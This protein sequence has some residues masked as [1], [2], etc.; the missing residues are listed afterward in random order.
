MRHLTPRKQAAQ[1]FER[2]YIKSYM[3][4]LTQQAT[5]T[6]R[7]VDNY[8][9]AEDGSEDDLKVWYYGSITFSIAIVL[10]VYVTIH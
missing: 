7:K 6:A 10:F 8:F 1:S 5:N 2:Q 4:L 9:F 3:K